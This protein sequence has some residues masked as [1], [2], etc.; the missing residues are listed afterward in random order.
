[1]SSMRGLIAEV[2]P[3]SA[4]DGPGNRYVVF[5]QGCSF[6]CLACHNPHTICRRE[7]ARSR[8]VEVDDVVADVTAAAPFLSGV[9]FSGGEATLQWPFV[10]EVCERL[11]TAPAT[12]S[13]GRLVDTNGDVE[14]DVWRHL[15]PVVDGAMVDLKAIDPDVHR[16][17][18]ARDNERV[19]ASI[20]WLAAHGRLT[21]VRLLIVPRVNDGPEQIDETAR[22]L[23]SLAEPAPVAVIPFRHDGTREVARRWDPASPDD[24]AAVVDR[25]RSAGV[26]AHAVGRGITA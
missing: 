8:W 12:A 6:D 23:G 24:V 11:A 7:T 26:A 25:L 20:R 13:L 2:V 19:L 5:L 4:V 22:F 16:M 1:M 21:E 10:R 15:A 14:L 9:T 18:T 17:L 3:A